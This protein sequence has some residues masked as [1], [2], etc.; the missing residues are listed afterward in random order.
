MDEMPD[1]AYHPFFRPILFRLP[2][3]TARRVTIELLATQAKLPGGPVLFEALAR[4]PISESLRT[5]FVDVDFPSPVGLAGGLDVDGRAA[6]LMQKLGLGFVELGPLGHAAR[7]RSRETNPL[8]VHEMHGLVMSSRRGA[9]AAAEALER[10]PALDIPLGV[11][12][13]GDELDAAVRR[14]SERAAFVTLP[15]EASASTAALRAARGATDRPLLA[16]VLAAWEEAELDAAVARFRSLGVD[17]VWVVAGTAH[18]ARLGGELVSSISL[19]RALPVMERIAERMP[20]ALSGGVLTPEDAVAARD[21]G[22]ALIGLSD[23]F[24]YAGPGL[25]Q[26]VNRRL[27]RPSPPPRAPGRTVPGP[28]VSDA[29][30]VRGAT[31]LALLSIAAAGMLALGAGY[32]ILALT[33]K[34]LPNDVTYLGMSISELCRLADCRIV[35][36]I[37]HDCAVYGGVMLANGTMCMWLVNGPLRRREPW[38]WWTLLVAGATGQ[39]AALSFIARDYFNTWHAVAIVSVTAASVCGLILTRPIAADRTGPLAA[40]RSGMA[41]AWVWSP[42]GR[43][44]LLLTA[45]GTSLIGGGLSIVGVASTRVFV[46]EDTAFMRLSAADLLRINTRLVPVITQDRAVFGVGLLMLG[47]FVLASAWNAVRPHARGAWYAFAIAGALHFTAAF[48]AHVLIGYTDFVHLFPIYWGAA[49]LALALL[50]LRKPVFH[51][52][53]RAP[54]FPDV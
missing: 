13:R 23:G 49:I 14:V 18:A 25:A 16:R 31:G 2:A 39:L 48:V 37:A 8:R 15:L 34:L 7:D 53:T 24:V 26:R 9:P 10:L 41:G 50:V 1:W 35:E 47:I 51:P 42:A 3:E 38:A 19:E 6:I 17:G 21:A 54:T 43:G 33:A 12:V 28:S 36:F 44:R 45:L 32:L 29:V 4:S 11:Q 5:R 22:A 27:E 20:V 40:L 52:P 30:G 46:P